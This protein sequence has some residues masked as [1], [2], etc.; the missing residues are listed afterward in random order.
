MSELI[1]LHI[2]RVSPSRVPRAPKEITMFEFAQYSLPFTARDWLA[3]SPLSKHIDRYALALGDEGYAAGTISI[4]LASV[5]HFVH[6][7][8]KRH[9]RLWDID[10]QLVGVFLDRHLPACRCARRC[11]RVRY[12]VRAAVLRFVESLRAHGHLAP[13]RS[14]NPAA[15]QAEL[16][17]FDI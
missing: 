8:S 13:K 1:A 15:I 3:Q 6:W 17:C 11:Q 10:E 14:G 9:I 2:F 12:T 4:Y 5:A 16:Q 7:I